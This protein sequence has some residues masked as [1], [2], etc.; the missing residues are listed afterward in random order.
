MKKEER[1][2]TGM[3]SRGEDLDKERIRWEASET[4]TGK[5]DEKGIAVGE[6]GTEKVATE[7]AFD[8]IDARISESFL[9]K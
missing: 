8:K 4:V 9:T 7:A 3:T 6:V 5:N 2:D 1:S